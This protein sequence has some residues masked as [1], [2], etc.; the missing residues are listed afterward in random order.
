MS[1]E[2]RNQVKEILVRMNNEKLDLDQF[3]E[4]IEKDTGG[5]LTFSSFKNYLDKHYE[6]ISKCILLNKK[7]YNFFK[8][9]FENNLVTNK[10][11]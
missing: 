5:K 6:N 11:K 3:Y 7:F 9:K 4:I 8:K 2:N 10:I 1:I